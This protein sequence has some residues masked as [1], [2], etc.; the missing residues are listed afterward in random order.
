[1]VASSHCK[2]QAAASL[3]CAG[4]TSP[5]T[6]ATLRVGDVLAVRDTGPDGVTPLRT[7]TVAAVED[8][9]DGL[10]VELAGDDG[11]GMVVVR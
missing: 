9:P 10:R 4:S 7:Y 5:T 1:M 8:T 3:N 6:T 2:R 11:A